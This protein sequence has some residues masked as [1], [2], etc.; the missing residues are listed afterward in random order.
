M[1]YHASNTRVAFSALRGFFG[2]Q[3][4]RVITGQLRTQDPD[5]VLSVH[6]ATDLQ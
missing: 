5:V 4:R 6:P 1:I 3:V 2:G